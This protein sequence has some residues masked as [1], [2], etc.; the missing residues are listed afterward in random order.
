MI[1]FLSTSEIVRFYLLDFR[2]LFNRRFEE[3]DESVYKEKEKRRE[4]RNARAFYLRD[5]KR[6]LAFFQIDLFT[7][8]RIVEV[9]KK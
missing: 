8:Y 2:I 4:E 5:R 9:P 6:F 7:K 1:V 3:Q